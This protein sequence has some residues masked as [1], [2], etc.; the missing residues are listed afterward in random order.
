MNLGNNRLHAM[1]NK[2]KHAELIIYFSYA[3]C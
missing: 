1:R 2:Y 3:L